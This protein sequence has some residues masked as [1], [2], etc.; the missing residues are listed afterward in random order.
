[1]KRGSIIVIEIL[2]RKWE[3]PNLGHLCKVNGPPNKPSPIAFNLVLINNIGCS[4]NTLLIVC[5]INNEVSKAAINCFK[6]VAK[7]KN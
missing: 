7:K 1:M 4:T 2:E 5:F 6:R 3:F